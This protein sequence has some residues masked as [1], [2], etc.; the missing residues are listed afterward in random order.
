VVKRLKEKPDAPPELPGLPH[1][2]RCSMGV[3]V[4]STEKLV[5]RVLED[6]KRPY[7]PPETPAEERGPSASSHDFGRDVIPRMI[8][9]DRVMAHR[10]GGLSGS[11]E[12]PYWRDVGTIDVYWASQMELLSAEAGGDGTFD[13]YD[14]DWPMRSCAENMPPMMALDVEEEGCDAAVSNSMISGGCVVRGARVSRSIVGSDVRI[15]AGSSIR[16]SIVM[17]RVRIGKRVSIRRGII[18]KDN[19]I[20]DDTRIGMDHAADSR[21]FKLS[22]SGVVVV[23]KAMPLFQPPGNPRQSR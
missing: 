4:F 12:E 11:S 22:D 7:C 21:H 17:D 8:E 20:P 2:C 19:S 1:R 23:P 6:S 13:L 3:Y 9:E 10:F 15:G 14:P 16:D 5:R 18:D